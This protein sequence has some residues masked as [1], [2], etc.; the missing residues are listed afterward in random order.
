MAA[1]FRDAAVRVPGAPAADASYEEWHAW[2]VREPAAFWAALWRR[3]GVIAEERPG[4]DPWDAVLTG[5]E[6]MAPPTDPDGPRWFTGARLNFA[7][8]LLRRRDEGLAIIA[9]DERGRRRTLTFAELADEVRRA[10]GALRA[11]GV[12]PGD[13]VAGFLPNIP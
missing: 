8:N 4:R 11:L 1:F 10:A 12:G 7:E 13:R 5:G 3:V 2:S 9:R 6:G